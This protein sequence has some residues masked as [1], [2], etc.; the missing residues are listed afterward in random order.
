MRKRTAVGLAA[1]VALLGA[2]A[3]PASA[4]T[5]A[6]QETVTYEMCYDAGGKMTGY[7]ADGHRH[8]EGGTY[9]G[10]VLNPD[11]IQGWCEEG[12]HMEFRYLQGLFCMPNVPA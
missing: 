1:G 6:E 8:C 3:G 2:V 12:Y 10:A 5:A 4:A 7:D 9:N 11:P